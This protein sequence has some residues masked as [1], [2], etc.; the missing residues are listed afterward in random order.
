MAVVNG[1]P[2]VGERVAAGRREERFYGATQMIN[3]L[4]RPYGAGWALVGDAGAH[5]DPIMALGICDALRDAELLADALDDGLSR[6]VPMRDAMEDYERRRNEATLPL[7][8]LNLGAARLGS[9][10]ANELALRAALRDNPEDTRRF[11]MAREGMISP[12][13]FFAGEN[14]ARIMAGARTPITRAA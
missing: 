3:F 4:R 1:M 5:K 2:E 9:A 13:A 11:Y 14:I 8:H 7:Y 12:R 10:P 6:R